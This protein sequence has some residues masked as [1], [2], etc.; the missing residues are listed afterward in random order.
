MLVEENDNTER[1]HSLAGAR[2]LN[3]LNNAQPETL[4]IVPALL[5]WFYFRSKIPPSYM[6]NFPRWTFHMAW[7]NGSK[8]NNGVKDFCFHGWCALIVAW[9]AGLS[10][11]YY[12]GYTWWNSP[13]CSHLITSSDDWV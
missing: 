4:F 5:Y 9:I 12:S 7:W 3:L 6:S 11:H 8:K 10:L 1:K 2:I 13:L